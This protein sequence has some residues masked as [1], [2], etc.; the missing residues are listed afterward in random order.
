MKWKSILRRLIATGCMLALL[1][2]SA[3][4]LSVEDA[5]ALLE[6]TYV[7]LLPESAYQATTLDELFAAIDDPYTYYMSA[8]EYAD[9]L[10]SVEQENSVTGIGA[11]IS[12][13][14]EG[15]LL[16][17]VLSGG[18]AAEAGLQGGDI[19]VAIEGESCAPAGEAHR[20]LLVG[21]AGTYVNV[22][23]RHADGSEEDYRLERRLVE[24]H[25][26]SSTLWD[27][28]IGYIDC[29]SFG[30]YTGYYFAQGI[31]TYDDEAHLWVVDL[32]SNSGGVTSS[33][34]YAIGTFTG[35]GTLLLLRDRDGL[36]RSSSHYAD[37][38]TADPVIVL[39]NGYS[40]SA[41]EIF[42]AD[43][44][45]C[46]AGIV[47]GDRTYGKGVAQVVYDDSDSDLFD[48]DAL[49]VTAYRFYSAG[50]NT[51]DLVGVVPTLLVN[52]AIAHDVAKLLGKEEPNYPDGYLRF[53]LNGWDF[54][55]D[56][57]EAQEE[58]NLAAF[59]ALLEALPPD[60][61]VWEGL[62]SR[63][64]ETTAEQLLEEYGGDGVDCRWF[65]DVS[66][67]DCADAINALATYGILNGDDTGSYSP[68]GALTRAQLCALMAQALG[69]SYVG[70]SYFTDV[71]EGRWYAGAVNAMA[72]L[73]FVDSSSD[74]FR[75]SD[76]LTQ[77]EFITFMGRL[78]AYLN[79]KAYE[80][81]RK[82]D[83]AALAADEDLAGYA[84]WARS[85]VDVMTNLVVDENDAPVSMLQADLADIDPQ[86][87]VLRG[88]AAQVLYNLLSGLGIL[89]Y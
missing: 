23:V 9:F 28:G 1:V 71:E 68:D 43:I 78:A 79:C 10:S 80:Y 34:V 30:T 47:V 46:R 61:Q 25:N 41:S 17:S 33:A 35:A 3:A 13:T 11:S 37:Y 81:I 45:D 74:L 21:E 16:I 42:A 58:A 69:V 20:A 50:G 59:Q 57:E 73:G 44:R 39:T 22:T 82:Q 63:W 6:E 84:D 40:A 49:K 19:I 76:P 7:D 5:R 65:T 87:T 66:G 12:Y 83:A 85:A 88:E 54:Y 14:D 55:L 15:I 2:T 62:R 70:T 67:S 24:I 52:G 75:P 86:A 27:G 60:V 26:T 31:Q 8:Q 36:Y 38:L 77:Q 29:D 18:A 48:G 89:A 51:N 56:L 53:H 32:R 72:K 64:T 4:A